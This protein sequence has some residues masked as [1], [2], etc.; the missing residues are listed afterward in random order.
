MR[1]VHVVADISRNGWGVSKVVEQLSKA[2]EN[3]S[4]SVYV[5]G[6]TSEQWEKTDKKKWGGAEFFTSK[7]FSKMSW[8]FSFEMYA[9]LSLEA[10][11]I[12]VH[13]LDLL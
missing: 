9:S 2:Q 3:L 6:L 13:G 1:I 11:I 10:D 4:Q 8:G 12:H 5:V 7:P